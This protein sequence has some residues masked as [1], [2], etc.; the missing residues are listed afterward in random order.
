MFKINVSVII[1]KDDRYLIQKRSSSEEA[2]PGLWG[3]PGGTVEWTKDAD[4]LQALC[5]EVYEEVGVKIANP[6]LIT[7]NIIKGEVYGILFMI[8]AADYAS[9]SICIGDNTEK[10]MW[11]AKQ[12]VFGKEFTPTIRDILLKQYE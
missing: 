10:V 4:L 7:D 3:I 5:R 6:I 11:A 12:D 9:G 8:F 1:K 2:Y